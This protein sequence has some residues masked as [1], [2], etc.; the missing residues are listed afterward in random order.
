MLK[1]IKKTTKNVEG[2]TKRVHETAG[3][4]ADVASMA[5]QSLLK[6]P[7]YEAL[8]K[9]DD[10]L[11]DQIEV[12]A[13]QE[14]ALLHQLASNMKMHV[15]G[16]FEALKKYK[17]SNMSSEDKARLLNIRESYKELSGA[18]ETLSDRLQEDIHALND[19]KLDIATAEKE[20]ALKAKKGAD[21]MHQIGKH[22]SNI[23]GFLG[24]GSKPKKTR[25]KMPFQVSCSCGRCN[26]PIVDFERE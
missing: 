8:A 2:T 10:P 15:K 1:S 25:T 18:L 13:K 22:A 6:L 16:Q 19:V 21:P 12:L 11:I 23:L 17:N 20:A 5:K 24:G 14:H 4:A 9:S 26:K 3:H 7:S